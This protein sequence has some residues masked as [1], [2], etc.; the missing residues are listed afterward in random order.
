MQAVRLSRMQRP[1]SIYLPLLCEQKDA[2]MQGTRWIFSCK[3]RD[4]LGVML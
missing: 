4:K 1:V 3:N 2:F